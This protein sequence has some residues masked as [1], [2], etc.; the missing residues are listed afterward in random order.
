MQAPPARKVPAARTEAA[1]GATAQATSASQPHTAAATASSIPHPLLQETLAE[2]S[3][4]LQALRPASASPLA[5]P[6]S[7]SGEEECSGFLLQCQLYMEI[8]ATQFVS[9]RAK[10]A[11]VISLLTGRALSWAQA[12]WN[13]N[14]P[15]IQSL[16]NFIEHF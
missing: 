3:H 8:N 4:A 12:L 16:S 15:A 2:L 1:Q 5:K 14:V 9:E 11:F 6:T 10:I 7:Y 13:V